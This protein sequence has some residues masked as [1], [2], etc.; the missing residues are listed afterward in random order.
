MILRLAPTSATCAASAARLA[1]LGVVTVSPSVARPN[2]L[3]VFQATR[4]NV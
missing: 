2:E 1:S 3:I 4:A